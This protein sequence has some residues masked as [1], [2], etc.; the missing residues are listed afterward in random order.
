MHKNSEKMKIDMNE[1]EDIRSEKFLDF[2][3]VVK[4]LGKSIIG[5]RYLVQHLQ[6]KANYVAKVI[7]VSDLNANLAR[8]VGLLKSLDHQNVAKVVD[9]IVDNGKLFLIFEQCTGPDLLE[10]IMSKGTHSE[11][12]ACIYIKQVLQGLSYLHSNEVLCRDLRPDNIHFFNTTDDSA[13]KITEFANAVD[14]K[15]FADKIVSTS[16]YLAPEVFQN[17]YTKASDIWSCG[18]ILYT[19][20]VGVPPFT[21]KT[22]ADV[23]KKAMKGVPGYKEKAWARISN[24]AKRVVRL[25]LTFD[26]DKRPTAEELLQDPWV[27]QSLKFLDTSKPMIARTFKNFKGFYSNSKMQNAIVNYTTENSSNE[28]MKKQA[29]EL[30]ALLDQNGDGKVSVGELVNSMKD[31]GVLLSEQELKTII[32]EVDTDKNGWIDFAEFLNVFANK[33]AVMARE[34]LEKTFEMYA[35]DGNAEV[36]NNELKRVLGQNEADSGQGRNDDDS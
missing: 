13:L 7:H 8:E 22:D 31:S 6:S 32:N 36:M 23:R 25:M 34:N 3:T 11:A 19:L 12:N 9:T 33:H 18:V 10:R 24:H 21:G 26:I 20:L 14:S 30:F 15:G 28:E 17:T 4:H 1:F 27:K 2:Y 5:E 16:H 35:A 29:A